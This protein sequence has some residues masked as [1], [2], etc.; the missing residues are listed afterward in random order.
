MSS[1]YIFTLTLKVV[2]A[3]NRLNQEW[4]GLEPF[5]PGAFIDNSSV[6]NHRYA[7]GFLNCSDCTHEAPAYDFGPDHFPSHGSIRGDSKMATLERANGVVRVGNRTLA[8]APFNSCNGAEIVYSR[9]DQHSCR[10]VGVVGDDLYSS[11]EVSLAD[12]SMGHARHDWSWWTLDRSAYMSGVTMRGPTTK[13]LFGGRRGAADGGTGRMKSRATAARY[14]ARGRTR[15]SRQGN[16]NMTSSHIGDKD[17]HAWFV[18][19]QHQQHA[20]S[21]AVLA[22][23][24]T[25]IRTNFPDERSRIKNRRTPGSL[26]IDH[27][28]GH[29]LP[30]DFL[31]DSFANE[32][33][34]ITPSL[35]NQDRL[36]CP[37][38]RVGAVHSTKTKALGAQ[39]GRRPR[40]QFRGHRPVH[41]P[42][43]AF[44]IT[45]GVR[46]R[47][48]SSCARPLRSP[49]PAC[50][51]Q[52][53]EQNSCRDA[54]AVRRAQRGR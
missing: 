28:P 1:S 47:T 5:R 31:L 41:P 38:F 2:I 7:Y 52:R 48:G 32:L 26:Y 39:T 21:G 19:C 29:P 30:L 17:E 3:P 4:C 27:D 8:T 46:R 16:K 15:T 24:N 9:Q 23:R 6:C 34:T 53:W 11:P 35:T 49:C 36:S 18:R 51:Y 37:L 40:L 43:L 14:A 13:L 45:S 44:F 42:Q 10:T 50:E 33:T 22:H 54:A 25:I 12:I 20:S